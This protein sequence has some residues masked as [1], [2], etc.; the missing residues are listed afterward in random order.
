MSGGSPEAKDIFDALMA[1]DD[2]GVSA[3]VDAGGDCSVRDAIGM[4]QGTGGGWGWEGGARVVS[5]VQSR[6]RCS[7]VELQ[8]P[9]RWWRK[10]LESFDSGGFGGVKS[11]LGGILKPS[12]LCVRPTTNFSFS[13]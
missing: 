13:G 3:Y 9:G 12:C 5:F 4:A 8:Q 10:S 11:F 1:G 6:R 7:L 2:G